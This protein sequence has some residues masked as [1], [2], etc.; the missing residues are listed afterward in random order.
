MDLAEYRKL[1][2]D[3]WERMA[4]GWDSWN[5]LLAQSAREPTEQMV[6][7]LAPQPGE[8]ILELAAGAGVGGFAAA[9]LMGREGRLIMTD[10][11]SHMVEAEKRRGGEL[12]FSNIEYR[13]MDAERMD[14]EDDSVDGVLCR[15]G[16]MLMADPAAALRETRRVL[17]DGGR[18]SF[19]VWGAPADNPWA[20]V[21]SRI[22]VQRGHMAAPESG[23]PGIFAMAEPARIEELVT[24]AGFERPR[25]EEVHLTWRFEDFEH[26]WRYSTE[27]AGAIALVIAKLD[28]REAAAVRSELESACERYATGSGGYDFPGVCINGLTR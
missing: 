1:S 12:G 17:R 19:S 6:A 24:G 5:D 3:I 26:F 28:D 18:L 8:T 22:L 11:A 27:I 25:L 13:V 4:A 10:F 9:A 21:P 20:T 15:W 14:L 2:H 16:Y 23:A 7:A